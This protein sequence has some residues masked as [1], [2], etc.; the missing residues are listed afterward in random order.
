M[1]MIIATALLGGLFAGNVDAL[2]LQ[3]PLNPIVTSHY[4]LIFRYSSSLE[5]D[6]QGLAQGKRTLLKDSIGLRILSFSSA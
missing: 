1:F 3:W 6:F 4:P 5:E 2:T